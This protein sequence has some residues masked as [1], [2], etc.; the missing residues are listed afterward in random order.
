M[1][2]SLTRLLDGKYSQ[3]FMHLHGL[4][5]IFRQPLERQVL[6]AFYLNIQEKVAMDSNYRLTEGEQKIFLQNQQVDLDFGKEAEEGQGKDHL[7][8]ERTRAEKAAVE[9]R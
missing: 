7:M 4:C 1:L 6:R 3:D 8:Q 2:D 5:Q 9:K